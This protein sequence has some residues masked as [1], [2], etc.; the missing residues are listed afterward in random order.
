MT[1]VPA[2][3]RNQALARADHVTALKLPMIQR[4][5]VCSE[6]SWALIWT[7]DRSA[8]KMAEVMTPERMSE[9]TGTWPPRPRHRVGDAH[10]Q[11][12][13]D[14]GRQLHGQPGRRGDGQRRPEGGAGGEAQDVGVH[15]R[16][17]QHALKRRPGDRDGHAHEHGRQD[18]G[19]PDVEEHRVDGMSSYVRAAHECAT[20]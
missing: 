5:I 11:Q 10:G 13:E 19:Q 15:E 2:T 18:A 16:V 1:T 9:T 17:A 8:V 7:M 6:R 3:M 12:A 20:R 4:T 14:E